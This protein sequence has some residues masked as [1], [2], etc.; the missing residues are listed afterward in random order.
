MS[1]TSWALRLF[2]I[3]VL[4]WYRYTGTCYCLVQYIF[5]APYSMLHP[6]WGK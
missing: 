5:L 3:D 2:E 4:E 1:M 6:T